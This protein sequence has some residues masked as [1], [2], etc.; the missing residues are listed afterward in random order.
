[1]PHI[2]KSDFGI[3]NDIEGCLLEINKTREYFKVNAR[4]FFRLFLMAAKSGNCNEFSK[5]YIPISY[6]SLKGRK[7]SIR[8]PYFKFDGKSKIGL[9]CVFSKKFDRELSQLKG[10]V[11]YSQLGMFSLVERNEHEKADYGNIVSV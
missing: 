4:R 7:L 11:Y 5:I 10:I 3:I 1:M 8:L 9:E 2:D 6:F